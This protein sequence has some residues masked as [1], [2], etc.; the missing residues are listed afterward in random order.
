MILYN[1][2]VS[3]DPE[4]HLDWLTWMRKTHIPDVMDT[5]CFVES[6]ISR[7]H[8]EEEGG[9]TFAISYVASTQEI[10]DNYQANHAPR[11]Q[12]EHK[13]K[14]AGRFAAFRTML[15]ILDEFKL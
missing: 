13:E 14:Y 7:V 1:V 15:T 5:G 4:I 6:R 10:F 12:Q 11:L 9:Y 2:T 3:I 8:G